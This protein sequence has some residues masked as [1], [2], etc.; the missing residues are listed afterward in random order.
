MFDLQT[1]DENQLMNMQ[2]Y[3]SYTYIW[4]IFT[5]SLFADLNASCTRA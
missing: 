3:L 5:V 4:Y 1:I 2:V